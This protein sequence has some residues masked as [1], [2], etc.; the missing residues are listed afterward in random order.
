MNLIDSMAVAVLIPCFNEEASIGQ[1]I[2]DM[3]LALPQARIIVFDNHSTD[4]TVACVRAQN[5]EVVQVALRGKG[6][7]VRRMFADIEADLYLMVDGDGTYDAKAA[8][9]MIAL[10]LEQGLDMVVG[11]RVE[12]A[13][14]DPYRPGHR[15]GNKLLT[16]ATK[17]IFGGLFTDM[18][19]GYRVFSRRF[20]KSFPALSRGFEIETELT[21]H[22]LEL[23]MPC[24]EF[25]TLYSDRDESFKV[26]HL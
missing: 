6:N 22:A 14:S 12:K 16:G 15:F 19:S 26:I 10:A 8:R 17:A 9:A 25:P 1:V 5:I 7:V 18:L 3:R 20:V 21:I 13:N 23:R 2:Q 24:G 4:Q 11:T